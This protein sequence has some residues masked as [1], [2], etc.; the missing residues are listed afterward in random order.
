MFSDK[1]MHSAHNK[2]GGDTARGLS[3]ARILDLFVCGSTPGQF[4]FFCFVCFMYIF[5]QEERIYCRGVH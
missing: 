2:K 3:A 1:W 4:L 5:D